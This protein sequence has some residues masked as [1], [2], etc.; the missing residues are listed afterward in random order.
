MRSMKYT[1][2]YLTA[3]ITLSFAA[4]LTARASTQTASITK[5][6]GDAQIFTHPS[7]TPHEKKTVD[8]GSMALFEGEYFLVREA[9]VGDTVEEGNILRTKVNGRARLVYENGDQIIVAPG[10]AYRIHWDAK[11]EKDPALDLMYGKVRGVVAKDGPRGKFTIRTKAATLGVRGTDFFV[12]E[13]NT[14]GETTLTVIRGSVEMKPV[15]AGEKPVEVKMGFS[16]TAIGAAPAGAKTPGASEHSESSVKTLEK[17]GKIEVKETSKEEFAVVQKASII[18]VLP[19]QEIAAMNDPEKKEGADRKIEALEKK[20]LETTA[21]DIK[22]YQPELY[23]KISGSMAGM[24]SV[25]E[26]NSKSLSNLEVKA[27][28]RPLKRKKPSRKEVDQDLDEDQDPYRQYF[29]S[30]N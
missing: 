7:K 21:K 18:P 1:V 26:L 25:Q 22:N 11:S 16:G 14:T 28:S 29:K 30:G 17:A 3:F 27:P 13:S 24:A 12:S 2:F 6:L 15:A 20:A 23:A 8:D 4:T 9:K 10:T 19:K 5:L